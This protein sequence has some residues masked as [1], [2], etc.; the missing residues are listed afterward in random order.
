[1][2]IWT[3][4]STLAAVHRCAMARLGRTHSA[5]VGK[6]RNVNR[7]RCALSAYSLDRRLDLIERE[8]MRCELLQRILVRLQQPDCL[9]H[10]AGCTATHPFDGELFQKQQVRFEI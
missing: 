2:T 3:G 7:S 6:D 10:L 1:M 4:P 8:V 5:N 9:F